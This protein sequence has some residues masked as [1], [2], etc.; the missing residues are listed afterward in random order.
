MPTCAEGHTSAAHDYRER[1]RGADR[2]RRSATCSSTLPGSRGVAA[3]LPGMRRAGRRALLGE[4]CGH[5]VALPAPPPAAE[6]A[7]APVVAN[8]RP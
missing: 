8:G 6:R 5:D 4:V 2:R 3:G 1:V 7:N